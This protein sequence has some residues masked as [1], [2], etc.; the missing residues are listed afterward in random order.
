M[1]V[2]GH[3]YYYIQYLV[4]NAYF[5]QKQKSTDKKGKLNTRRRFSKIG[6]MASRV[7]F[8]SNPKKK[9]KKDQTITQLQKS[10]NV[11]Y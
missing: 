8:K 4:F 7:Q 9:K 6:R 11:Q 3:F 1:Q 2:R 5:I 10:H